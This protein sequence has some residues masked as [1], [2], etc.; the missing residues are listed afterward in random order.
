MRLNLASKSHPRL[1]NQADSIH[2]VT[3]GVDQDILVVQTNSATLLQE[4]AAASEELRAGPDKSLVDRF[5][6]K[7][8]TQERNRIFGTGFLSIPRHHS[9]ASHSQAYRCT[10]NLPQSLR[11]APP[12]FMNGS[13]ITPRHQAHSVPELQAARRRQL[14]VLLLPVPSSS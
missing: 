3:Q 7:D 12:R 5:R 1:Q 4:S 2:Q 9:Q 8:E 10:P 11:S 13:L 14:A 6:L